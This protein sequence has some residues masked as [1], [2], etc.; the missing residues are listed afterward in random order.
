MK[1]LS[2]YDGLMVPGDRQQF[3]SFVMQL[4]FSKKPQSPKIAVQHIPAT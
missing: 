4:K 2:Y 3:L 1:D